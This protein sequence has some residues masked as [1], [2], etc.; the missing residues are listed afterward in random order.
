[1]KLQNKRE[2]EVTRAKLRDLECL[3]DTTA[4][5]PG[6][7]TYARELTLRSLKRTIK[8]FKEEIARFEATANSTADK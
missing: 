3:Y 6:D 7:R 5:D 2:L 8:Q 1:M 4:A